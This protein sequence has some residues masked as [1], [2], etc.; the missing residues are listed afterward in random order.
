ME[1]KMANN[2]K[3][4]PSFVYYLLEKKAITVA[5][6]CISMFILRFVLAYPEKNLI[7][8]LGS[9]IEFASIVSASVIAVLIYFKD[10]VNQQIVK[11]ILKTEHITVFGLGEFNSALLKNEMASNNSRYVIFEKNKQNDKLDLFRK[12]GMG[13]VEG[14]VFNEKQLDILN[15]KDMECGVISLGNDRLNIELATLIIDHYQKTSAQDSLKLVVHIIN[16]DLNALFHQKFLIPESKDKQ[17]LDIQT[18]SFYEEAAEAFFENNCAEGEGDKILNSDE[19]YHMVVAGDGELAFNIIYQTAKL[20]HLPN[21]NKLTI[22][23][24][25]KNAS[26]FKNRIIKRYPGILNVIGLDAI[27]L[28][29]ECLTYFEQEELWFKNNL[30]HVIVCYDDEERNLNIATDLFNKTY[31]ASIG[32]DTLTTRISFGSFNNYNMS[33]IIDNDKDSFKQ[34]FTFADVKS[35]C[36]R[37]NVL[38]EEHELIA[39]LIH[40]GYAERFEPME[41]YSLDD[42]SVLKMINGKWHDGLKLHDKLSNKSQS[43]HIDMKLKA[44]GLKKVKSKNTA[45]ELLQSNLSLFNE[46]LKKDRELLG[47]SDEFIQDYSLELPKIWDGN[48]GS[49]QVKYFPSEY[50]CMLEKLIRSEHNR[51]NAF[52]FLNGWKYSEYKNKRTKYHDC[53]IPLAEFVKPEH[54]LTVIYD[55][56]SILYLPNYLANGGYEITKKSISLPHVKL[57]I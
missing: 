7:S 12:F 55:L 29:N 20:A 18:F 53:L 41:Q 6:V 44:L 48:S 25:D 31:L 10:A 23:L 57:A 9:A 11:R 16:Q 5:T 46:V 24:I 33:K 56:Y 40:N 43:L 49:I 36:T 14:D 42:P 37:E 8:A 52:H 1:I 30:T 54:K 13:V 34:F 38:D 26:S 39:K 35:I 45:S 50:H 32:N 27:D 22:H 19:D 51:W 3:K 4:S 28:D 17:Q 15:F 47:L 21:E 2:T